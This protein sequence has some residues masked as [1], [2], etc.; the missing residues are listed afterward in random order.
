MTW[1]RDQ[2]W[3]WLT[4]TRS[5]AAVMRK[6]YWRHWPTPAS[7]L[8]RSRLANRRKLAPLTM[9]AASGCV[10]VLVGIESLVFRHPG[11]GPKQAEMPRI[12]DAIDAIQTNGVAVNG[13][14][15]WVP[16]AKHTTRWTVSASSSNQALAD[17]QLTLQTPFPSTALRRRLEREGRLLA[18]RGWSHYTPSSTSPT[19]PTRW[20]SWN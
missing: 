5:R 13:C 17:V 18:N 4:T 3:N 20:V 14:S 9:L 1:S 15:S 8:Y 16:M 10:Q 2:F 19:S 6:T 11:M 7:L 12:M